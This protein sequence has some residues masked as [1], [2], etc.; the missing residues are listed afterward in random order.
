MVGKG[1]KD[2]E[3]VREEVLI[4]MVWIGDRVSRGRGRITRC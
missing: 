3:G 4:T 2:Y 1:D